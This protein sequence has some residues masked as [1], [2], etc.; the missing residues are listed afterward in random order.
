MFLSRRLSEVGR[1][2]GLVSEERYAAV[3]AKYAAAAAERKRLEETILPPTEELNALLRERGTAEVV[4]GVSL[5]DLLRRPQLTYEDLTSLDPDS[6]TLSRAIRESVEID[7]KYEGYIRRQLRQVEEFRRMEE[8]PL[9]AELDYDAV[10]GLRTEARQKLSLIRPASFGQASR[11]SGVSPAD[12]AALMIHMSG[13][14][15]RHER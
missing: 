8:R 11:I 3:Q 12:M 6:P 15:K 2:I 14:G 7:L 5:A 9:P 1:R 13:G 4:S 10:P